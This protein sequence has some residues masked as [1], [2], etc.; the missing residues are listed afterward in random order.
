M[1]TV[2]S[3]GINYHKKHNKT[4]HAEQDA[5]SKLPIRKSRKLKK[6]NIL[7]IRTT[8]TGKINNSKPCYHCIQYMINT[9]PQYGYKISNVYF[10]TDNGSIEKQKLTQLSNSNTFHV[11]SYYRN[12]TKKTKWIK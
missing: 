3:K 7:V 10:S 1:F 6:I 2:V 9:T 8:G 11:S 4:I 5:I 12:F